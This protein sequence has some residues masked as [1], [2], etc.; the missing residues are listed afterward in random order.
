MSKTPNMKKRAGRVDQVVECLP[1]KSKAL[2]S[3]PSLPKRKN[4]Y[5]FYTYRI[6][7]AFTSHMSITQCSSESLQINYIVKET[8]YNF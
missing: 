6:F 7:Q 1:S 5:I 4:Q 8:V 2:S 3:N